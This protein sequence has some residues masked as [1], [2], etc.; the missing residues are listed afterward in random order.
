MKSLKK[1]P[2]SDELSMQ[3]RQ[4]LRERIPEDRKTGVRW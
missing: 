2:E 4:E 3:A 1:G